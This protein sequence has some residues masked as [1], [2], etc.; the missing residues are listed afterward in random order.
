MLVVG[1]KTIQC[2]LSGRGGAPLAAKLSMLRRLEDGECVGDPRRTAMRPCDGEQIVL[3][4]FDQLL[5]HVP[6]GD[7]GYGRTPSDRP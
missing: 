2:G 3:V 4:T 7:A 6:G 1:G 5:D